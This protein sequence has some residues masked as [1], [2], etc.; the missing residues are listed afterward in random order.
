V[1]LSA[2]GKKPV[3][4]FSVQ[5]LTKATFGVSKKAPLPKGLSG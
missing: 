2:A 4:R 1:P 5:P 3:S